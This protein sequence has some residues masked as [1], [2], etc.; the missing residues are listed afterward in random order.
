VSGRRRGEKVE[1]E[2]EREASALPRFN[3]FNA[4]VPFI[5]ENK[6]VVHV[7]VR[8]DRIKV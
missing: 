1:R 6:I 7:S 2:R 8:T 3:T 5:R 4:M